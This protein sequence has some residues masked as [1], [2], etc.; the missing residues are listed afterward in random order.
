MLLYAVCIVLRLARYNALLV[1]TSPR[2]EQFLRRHARARRRDRGDR[3]AGGQAAVRRRLVDV[4]PAVVR[5]WI[6]GVSLLVVSPIPMRKVHTFSI[7]PSMVAPLLV[8]LADRSSR[9][10]SFTPTSS[11]ADHP[12]LL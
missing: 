1:E 9:R 7:S 4:G 5:I 8:L 2:H 10:R 3:P 11:S 12:D 6:I